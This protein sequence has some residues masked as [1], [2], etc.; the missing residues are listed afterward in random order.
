MLWK[1]HSITMV[2]QGETMETKTYLI[3][4]ESSDNTS[5]IEEIK[6]K[7]VDVV[8]KRVS[9]LMESTDLKIHIWEKKDYELYMERESAFA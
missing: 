8:L 7:D 6:T 1:Y 3:I 2:L 4:K 9:E 5:E